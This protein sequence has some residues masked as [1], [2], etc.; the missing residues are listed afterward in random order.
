[1]KH[2]ALIAGVAS[3]AGIILTGVVGWLLFTMGAQATTTPKCAEETVTS[4]KMVEQ[5]TFSPVP[6]NNM[7]SDTTLRVSG[8]MFHMTITYRSDSGKSSAQAIYDGKGVLYGK[9]GDKEWEKVEKEDS[10]T[11]FPFSAASMCPDT[12]DKT[13]MGEETLNDTTVKHYQFPEGSKEAWD[14]W[15]SEDGWLVQA[16][17]DWAVSGNT[18]HRVVTASEINEPQDI[19]VPE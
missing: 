18:I 12:T 13:Y 5:T 4:Y 19:V 3:V 15:V 1:M 6:E 14:L 10:F 2:M 11:D 7:A 8:S 17:Y 16:K 9:S